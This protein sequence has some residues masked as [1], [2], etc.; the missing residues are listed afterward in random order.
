MG[1]VSQQFCTGVVNKTLKLGQSATFFIFAFSLVL[2]NE[3]N[4]RLV[5]FN[6]LNFYDLEK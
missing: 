5:K 4:N 1:N 2:I 3:L 6:K